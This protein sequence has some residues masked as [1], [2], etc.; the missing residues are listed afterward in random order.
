ML[1]I[2]LAVSAQLDS[3]KT[4]VEND[5]TFMS[6]K[7]VKG[8][9]LYSISKETNVSQDSLLLFNP[10]LKDGLK[11]GAELKIPFKQKKQKRNASIEH[12]VIAKET[13]FGI[14]K[15][16]KISIDDLK[17]MNPELEKGLKI[18][19]VLQINP[20][21]GGKVP[22]EE[23][24]QLNEVKKDSITSKVIEKKKETKECEIQDARLQK[25]EVNIALLL[26]LFIGV[27]EEINPKS[28]IGLDFYAGAK[29][30]LD[31]LRKTGL[32]AKV[33]LYD[34][35]ND[36]TKITEIINKPAFKFMD[37]IIGPLYTSEFKQVADFAEKN[38]ITIISP[39]AQSESIL[40]NNN[41]VLKFTPES[42]TMIC[43]AV[44]QLTTINKNAVFTLI[45]NKNEADRILADSIKSAYQLFTGKTIN[46]IEFTGVSE[47]TD[48]LLEAN[49]NIV[50]F[51]ST[52][53][54]QV[55]DFTVRLNAARLGKRITLVGLNEWNAYENIDFDLLNNLNFVYATQ[56]HNNYEELKNIEFRNN[57]KTEFKSEP[58]Q[59]AFQGFDVAFFTATQLK[60]FGKAFNECL[61]KIP[62]FCGFNS[63]YSFH[64]INNKSG[65]MNN[66][67]N[68]VQLVDFKPTKINK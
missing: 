14:A 61:P 62:T 7:I 57:F 24:L 58:S 22:K 16:Y 59:Y 44:N 30:A 37:L 20:A 35:Q 53:Q 34:T 6:Y 15:K 26:P 17:A 63:C 52:I 29:I 50:I 33:F 8:K 9:T 48:Q 47:L 5:V 55:I 67:V 49:E 18:G 51:P 19:M 21:S 45:Y 65:Y 28:K 31:S 42:K 12:T 60:L 38:N 32:N 66:Y 56:N 4:F 3:S 13:E 27:T 64:Q 25:N 23:K 43:K 54:I 2:G 46:T 41:H 68:V 11:T 40:K 39:F 36:S 1:A 10:F